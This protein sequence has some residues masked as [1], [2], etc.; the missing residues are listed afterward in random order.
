MKT[1]ALY[2]GSFDPPHIA[3]EAIVKALCEL[4]FLDEII[5]MP[6]YLNPFKKSFTTPAQVRLKWLQKIFAPYKKV[7]VSSFEVDQE[8]KVPTIESVYHLLQKYETLYL[9]IGADNVKAL[10]KW[11]RYNELKECVHFIVATRNDIKVPN[12]FIKL[13]IDEEISSS[14]LRE[15]LDMSKLP[16]ACAQDIARYYK[17][18]NANKN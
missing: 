12:D 9:V 14:D 16:K 5:V 4:D 3:H 17:E 8:K 13:K 11:H 18:H 10:H 7:T 2:G 1:I 15:H 6:T